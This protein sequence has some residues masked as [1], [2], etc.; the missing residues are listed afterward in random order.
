LYYA[1]SQPVQPAALGN[2]SELALEL[3]RR[4]EEWVKI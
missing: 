2:N 4:S 3:W 1:D